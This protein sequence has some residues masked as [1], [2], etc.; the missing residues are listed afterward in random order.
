MKRSV[1]FEIFRYAA[2][3]SAMAV[4]LVPILWMVSM[5]FKPIGEWSATGADLTWW[6]KQPTLANFQF[7]FGHST[8]D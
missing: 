6:P 7:V 8:N 1:P 4:T 2:I 3:L 5:A